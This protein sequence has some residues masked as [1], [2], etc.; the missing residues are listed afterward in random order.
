MR[1]A[2][3]ATEMAASASRYTPDSMYQTFQD[4]GR[5][6]EAFGQ[7]AQAVQVTVQRSQN[8][9]P[10]HP[11]VA[12]QLAVVHQLLV[13]AAEASAQVAPAMRRVHAADLARHEQPRRNEGMWNVP[14]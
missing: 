2:D 4:F 1:F 12:Q 7:I 9:F 10:L 13:K 3:S 14:K 11:A 8:E 5:F 6:P